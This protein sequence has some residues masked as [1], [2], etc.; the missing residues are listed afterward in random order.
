V[1]GIS[2]DSIIIRDEERVIIMTMS[3]YRERLIDKWDEVRPVVIYFAGERF[4][5]EY[6]EH[7][8]PMLAPAV[9]MVHSYLGKIELTK[10]DN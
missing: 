5:I 9:A 10:T 2:T 4:V 6:D 3:E 7:E 8:D 1:N